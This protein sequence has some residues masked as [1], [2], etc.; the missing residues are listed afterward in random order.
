MIV[1]PNAKINLGLNI[2]E[3]RSDG[4]HNL[5]TVFYPVKGLFDAL[6]I[7]E[8]EGFGNFEITFS[9]NEIPGQSS[10]NICK[11]A[12]DLI[13]KNYPLKSIKV[14]LHKHIPIGAGLGGG[15]SDGAFFIKLLN[16]KLQLNLSFGELHHY[17]KQLGSDCS[18]FIN[19]KP[20]YAT[21][22]GD[23]MEQINIDLSGKFIF[24][25]YPN[26]FISTPDAYAGIIPLQKS[27]DLE[28]RIQLP[29][30]EWKD[31]IFNDFENSIFNKYPLL[32]TIKNE[33]YKQGALYASM[34]GS[35]SAMF[36]IFENEPK[37]I[38]EKAN[39]FVSITEL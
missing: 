9:G 1:F 2:I 24:L 23:Q 19:N 8:I 28:N 11:K 38:F 27:I 14:H 39:Y 3:K 30:K 37:N 17:A 34:S 10:D 33:F 32:E 4:F 12:Y 36:G 20:S 7:I 22:K 6:E 26:I 35:G 16:E 18:F 25:V 21:G 5:E 15:S 31:T 29:I 13:S